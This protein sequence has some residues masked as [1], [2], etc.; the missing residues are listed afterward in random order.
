MEKPLQRTLEVV[1]KAQACRLV[2]SLLA[3]FLVVGVVYVYIAVVA[4]AVAAAAIDAVVS[5][6]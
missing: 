1:E 4:A 3:R 6:M 5:W 2:E